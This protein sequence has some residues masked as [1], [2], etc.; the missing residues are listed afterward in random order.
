MSVKPTPESLRGRDISESAACSYDGSA[1]GHL[2]GLSAGL[3]RP[4][5]EKMFEP[6]SDELPKEVPQTTTRKGTGYLSNVIEN[7]LLALGGTGQAIQYS[8]TIYCFNGHPDFTELLAARTRNGRP[9]CGLPDAGI[10]NNS[11]FLLCSAM[12]VG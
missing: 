10:S 7:Y 3:T 12:V 8:M 6:M 2:P 9:I 1:D 4:L 11:N 5:P